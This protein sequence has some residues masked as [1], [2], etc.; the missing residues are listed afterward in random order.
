MIAITQVA[1]RFVQAFMLSNPGTVFRQQWQRLFVGFTQFRAV[2][3]RIQ[4]ANRRENTPQHIVDFRQRL[5]E[6]FPGVRRA[7]RNHSLNVFTAIVQRLSDGRHNVFW[8]NFRK[9]RQF[10]GSQQW[11]GH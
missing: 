11:I 9:R 2:F 3:H 4:V 8:L 5:A 6:I 7:L 10:E 1:V